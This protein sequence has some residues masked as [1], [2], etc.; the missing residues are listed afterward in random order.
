[1]LR[2]ILKFPDPRLKEKSL[3]VNSFDSSL[4]ELVQDMV[5]TMYAAPG[6]GLAAPQIGVHQQVI[7]VDLKAGSKDGQLFVAINPEVMNPQGEQYGEE[8]CLSVPDIYESVWCSQRIVLRAQDLE[9]KTW[10]LPAEDLLARCFCHEI[11][12]LRG[13]LFIDRLSPLKRGLVKRKLKRR[14]A[15]E[16]E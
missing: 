12:H 9:G 6:I 11:D 14:A 3:K 2:P 13:I 4:R 1:M 5:E 10:E 7:V 15:S 8:G 16:K